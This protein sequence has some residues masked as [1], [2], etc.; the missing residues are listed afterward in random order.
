MKSLT[1]LL[2]DLAC[3]F[4]PLVASF[5]PKHAFY[6]RWM[7]FIKANCIV[8]ILFLIWDY[9]F[10]AIGVWGF[11]PE[12]LT[13]IFIGNLP[14]EEVLFFICI[15]FC[16]VFSYFAFTYLVKR[17]PFTSVQHHITTILIVVFTILAGL[18]FNHWYTV[19]ACGFTALYLMYLKL[20]KVDLAFHYLT[21]L[22]IL[23]FFFASNGLL[24]GSFLDAPIV[25]YNDAENMGIRMFTIPIEDSIYGLLLIFLNIEGFR[26]FENKRI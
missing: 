18:Y 2:I 17:S 23:P 12:Y 24:T 9:I 15:P 8:T 6:K 22:F 13:G 11:N 1:Y 16:C 7:S 19:T 25:W 5:Y 4:V 21:F 3:V 20:K 14:L 10:T 26:Y